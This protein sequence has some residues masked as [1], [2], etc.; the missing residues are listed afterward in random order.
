MT[1]GNNSPTSAMRRSSS[2]VLQFSSL[3]N[4]SIGRTT[5][6]SILKNKKMITFSQDIPKSLYEETDDLVTSIESDE[7]DN[8][9][10][11]SFRQ[12]PNKIMIN[13]D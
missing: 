5:P 13:E 4:Q 1:S 9:K 8:E 3:P 7:Y 11:I 12:R 10:M 6:N 2:K